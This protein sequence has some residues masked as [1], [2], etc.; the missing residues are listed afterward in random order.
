[1][2]SHWN[3]Y[4]PWFALVLLGRQA[5]QVRLLARFILSRTRR[6]DSKDEHQ[7]DWISARPARNHSDGL[8]PVS[9]SLRS[10]ARAQFC[11][12]AGCK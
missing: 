8:Q 9:M 5:S 6:G 2:P 3:A 7:R 1:M 11:A 10:G 4:H 12:L